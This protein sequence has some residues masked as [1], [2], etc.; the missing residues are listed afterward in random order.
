MIAIYA[1]IPGGL[2][3]LGKEHVFMKLNKIRVFFKQATKKKSYHLIA[4]N[5]S[6]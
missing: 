4:V 5:V 2:T 3:V 6:Q 1:H